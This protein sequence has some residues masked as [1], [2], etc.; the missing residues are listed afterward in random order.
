M[1]SACAEGRWG[2][3]GGGRLPAAGAGREGGG[4]AGAAPVGH[5]WLEPGSGAGQAAAGRRGGFQEETLP[6]RRGLQTLPAPLPAG[7]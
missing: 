6:H 4:K 2:C 3:E 5:R 1:C 7:A